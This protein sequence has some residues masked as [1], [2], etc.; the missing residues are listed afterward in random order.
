MITGCLWLE[1]MPSKIVVNRLHLEP[2]R[3]SLPSLTPCIQR[4]TAV[5][6]LHSLHTTILCAACIPPYTGCIPSHAGCMHAACSMHTACIRS[7]AGCIR[8]YDRIHHAYDRMQPAY[9]RMQAAYGRMQAAY[10]RMQAAYDGKMQVV[11]MLH[12]GLG[13][14]EGRGRERRGQGSAGKWTS[15]GWLTPH[16]RSPEKYP[17]FY[18]RQQQL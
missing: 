18:H 3:A 15:R 5:C 17:G 1:L 9:A 10:R 16:V 8:W 2:I 11:C 7:Y 4:F 6:S 12:A 14:R 13:L